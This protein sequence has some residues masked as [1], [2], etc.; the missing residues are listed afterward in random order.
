MEGKRLVLWDWN[1]CLLD[2]CEWVYT[3]G[4]VRIFNHFDLPVPPLEAYRNEVESDFMT[5]FYW[6]YGIPKDVTAADL[7]AIMKQGY[8]A[9]GEPPL[10]DDARWA[11][12]G[13]RQQEW[14]QVLVTA[15]NP[16]LLERSLAHHGIAGFF[17]ETHAGVRKKEPVFAD[18]LA[19]HGVEPKDAIGVT[20]TLSDVAMLEAVGVRPYIVPRGFHGRA[21]IDAARAA[22]PRMQVCGSLM[23]VYYATA[24]PLA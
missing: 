17:A 10:Q 24:W 23:S 7:D 13:F 22:H 4:P 12:D 9:H 6:K 18:V 21:R 11:L 8:D 2:D 5:S 19:R 16:G 3:H 14:T 15:F 20:D 1:G